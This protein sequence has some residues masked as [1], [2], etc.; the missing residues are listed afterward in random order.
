MNDVMINASPVTVFA[1]SFRHVTNTLRKMVKI[2]R[3][4]PIQ[5][6]VDSV[7][8]EVGLVEGIFESRI[9][10]QVKGAR[11]FFNVNLKHTIENRLKLF[12]L[13]GLHAVLDPIHESTGV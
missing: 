6:R 4:N 13:K 3:S 11:S 12:H 9:L 1:T 5:L 2:R 8:F 7:L 10:Q